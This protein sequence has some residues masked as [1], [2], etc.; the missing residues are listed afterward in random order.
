MEKNELQIIIE[1]SQS[2]LSKIEEWLK[3]EFEE[4]D[5]GFYHNWLSIKESPFKKEI[6]VLSY[7]NYPIGFVIYY[8]FGINIEIE[9]FA[10]HPK[11]VREGFG[12]IF[13]N[14]IENYFKK[15]K[16]LAV[17][18]FCS[19]PDSEHF[20][21]KMGFIK[22]PELMRGQHKRTYY[23]TLIET[24]QVST[25]K[26]HNNKIEL[27]DLEPHQAN[28]NP[29]KWTWDLDSKNQVQYPIIHPCNPDWNIRWI[30]DS[31]IEREE[32]VKYFASKNKEILLNSFLYIPS[33]SRENN[34][35]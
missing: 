32:K 13:Y 16:L 6:I 10:I 26:N 4:K 15:E 33:L 12:R 27:W 30:K 18:L 29:P 8:V 21:K 20:W 3:K 25:D 23:K 28:N 35:S 5:E 1:P 11:H 24:Q 31:N 9:I 22:F 2:D 19:P 17:K 7:N 34:D 14:K